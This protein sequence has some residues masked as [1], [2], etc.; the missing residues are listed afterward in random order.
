MITYHNGQCHV[1]SEYRT[2]AA[3]DRFLLANAF[4]AL[5]HAL[6]A[7]LTGITRVTLHSVVLGFEI[8][9]GYVLM[10]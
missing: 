8:S 2:D 1:G 9:R 6:G 7:R 5:L 10:P 3:R 4:D